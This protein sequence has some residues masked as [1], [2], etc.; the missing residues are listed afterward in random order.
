MQSAN[1]IPHHEDVQV[2]VHLIVI[3]GLIWKHRDHF[4]AGYMSGGQRMTPR[5]QRCSFENAQLGDLFF[6]RRVKGPLDGS[7]EEE[8]SCWVLPVIQTLLFQHI[9]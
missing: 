9:R 7:I 6:L 1:Q 5:D 8:G 4:R 2:I 3:V